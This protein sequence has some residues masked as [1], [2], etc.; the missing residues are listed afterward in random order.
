MKE[1]TIFVTGGSGYLGSHLIAHLQHEGGY[2]IGY[3][4][5]TN[6]VP[7]GTFGDAHGCRV[8]LA[9]GEGLDSAFEAL[10]PVDVVVNTAAIS[11]PA[12]CEKDYARARAANVPEKLLDALERQRRA[13]GVEALLVHISTDQVYEGS[14][15]H[16]S[17]ADPTAPVNAY[18]R[19]KLEAE[20]IIRARW[21][22]AVVLRA[23]LIYG[24]QPPFPVGRP[25]FVQFVEDSLRQGK[26]TKF[27]ADEFRC[28]VFVFD[29]CRVVAHLARLPPG[30]PAHN[31]YNLG[32]PDRM[33]RVDMAVAVARHFGYDLG[34]IVSI[35]SAEAGDRGYQ[36]P[37]DI[38]MV[39]D[40]LRQDLPSITLTSFAQGLAL[41][42]PNPPK[43]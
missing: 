16:W 35:P 22:R 34:A 27:F 9:T 23:S 41:I 11:Q 32:G 24:P 7:P 21:P 8:D 31:T 42:F 33:S 29:I 5:L 20:E 4:F 38:S 25:L 43:Q 40:R 36:S 17:E 26:P 15:A 6:D 3:S 14:R 30:A 12:L 2:R 1:L 10:G 39:M 37:P 13:S 28:P 18:G 19:S